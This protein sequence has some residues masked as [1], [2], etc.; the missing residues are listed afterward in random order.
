M[1][2]V[3]VAGVLAT[4]TEASADRGWRGGRSGYYGS[5]SRYSRGC[6]P[7]YYAP[8]SCGPTYYSYRSYSDCGDRYYAPR[9]SGFGFSFGYSSGRSY[10]NDCGPRY[11]SYRDC[12][13]RSYGR[14]YYSRRGCR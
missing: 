8:R 11:R 7:S 2:V 5:Y 4:T 3:A 12:G 10:Y 14:S 13:P 9:S 6:G 1:L